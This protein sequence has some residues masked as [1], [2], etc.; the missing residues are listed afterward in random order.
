MKSFI[1]QSVQ[2]TI[3]FDDRKLNKL[4]KSK[5]VSITGHNVNIQ[6]HLSSAVKFLGTHAQFNGDFLVSN[7]IP[8]DCVL[9]WDFIS[10][11]NL[12]I[13]QGVY[14]GNYILV[15]KHGATPIISSQ[16]SITADRV[17]VVESNPQIACVNS[18]AGRLLCQSRFQ[19][20]TGVSLVESVMIP[21][22]TE[23][24]L[25]GKLAKRAKSNV[26]MLEPCSSS[27]NAARQGFNIA[28]VVVKPDNR[29]VPLCVLNASNSP[30]EL[31]AGEHL[32]DFCP[33]I[34][35]CL[36]QPNI[37]GAVG[38]SRIPQVISD[39]IESIIDP[40]LRGEE[41]EKLRNLLSEFSD[42]F[43][44]S[45]GHTNILAHEI[46]TGNNTPIKQ[47]PHRSLYAHREESERQINE[48]LEKGI[49]CESTSPWSSPIILVKKDGEMRFCV[50]YRKLNSVTVGH[51]HPLP[52]VDDI[53]DSLGNSQYFS[54]IDL[55]S[56]YWQISV[57]E[58][59]RHKTAFVTQPGLFEFNRMPFGLV[60]A[61]TTFQRAM[62]LV[63]SGLSYLIC[64]CY[65]DDVIVFGRD[66]NEH[67]DRLKMVL[68]RLRSHNLRAKLEKCTIAAR[69][70][71]FLGHVVSASGIMP[72]PAK[73]DAVNNITSPRNI[74]DIRSFLG[75]VG[76]YRKF[77]PGFSSIA[78]PLLK[79]TQKSAHFNWTDA[80]EQA[81]QQLKHY[82]LPPFWHILTSVKSLFCKQMH[83]I[84]VLGRFCH[85]AMH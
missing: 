26:G 47:H 65:L 72:D 28:R 1:S 8:Y 25:E 20:N 39:K 76:Y 31:A 66:F 13:C 2:R 9:G 69:Q 70:V 40:S 83:L 12:S 27:S 7:N 74:K 61:P 67:Y 18:Q 60:N 44:E 62:D 34:A 64:L 4:K 75:L 85:N 52:R 36:S 42:V 48:M 14:V 59:D 43:D 22:R 17:G 81:F 77:I 71:S 49:I 23:I 35:S 63:L 80:C 57:N 19:G 46:D 21:P 55:K 68:E 30:I 37:C 3:D 32:A 41:R 5:C 58:R 29:I 6:G 11:N 79:L 16:S 15:G 38:N 82:V 50:D 33:L 24:M 54:T 10:Q 45:L 84:M 56:A 53:L 51:A 73:I 78:A